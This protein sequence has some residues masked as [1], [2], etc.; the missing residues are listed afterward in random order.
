MKRLPI[1]RRPFFAKR[2][3]EIGGGHD[4][5]A[6]VTH[7]VDKFPNDDGQRA[8]AMFV[9]RGVEFR[10][11]DLEAIPYPDEPKFD[12]VYLSHVLEHAPNPERAIAELVR[13]AKA[14]YVETPSPLR[15]QIAAPMPFA[16][17]R[18]FH[19][20]FV[21]KSCLRP[22]T[23]AY[24][25][26]SAA[27]L[28]EFPDHPHARVAERLAE[29]ARTKRADI[30]PLLPRDAKTTRIFFAGGLEILRYE[31][32]ADAYRAGEDPYASVA[33]AERASRWPWALRSSRFRRLR[34]LLPEIQK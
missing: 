15:E 13:V 23:L 7:A 12:F 30:E 14:G 20:N 27:T 33:L 26:K 10:E 17:D 6:G 9:A 4:P 22:N 31:S 34:D 8:G 21:W 18:D 24:I 11:G 25:R 3:L 2:I 19:L 29:I 16:G 1:H 5:Y 32:F 28:G